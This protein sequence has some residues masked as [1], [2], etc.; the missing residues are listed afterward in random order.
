[1]TA[2]TQV[3]TLNRAQPYRFLN[4]CNKTR[5]VIWTRQRPKQCRGKC[6]RQERMDFRWAKSGTEL[7]GTS[8]PRCLP[9]APKS[10]ASE[11]AFAQTRSR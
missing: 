10:H 1:M 4:F 3:A 11:H 5:A 9:W 2:S 6:A 7:N 8:F